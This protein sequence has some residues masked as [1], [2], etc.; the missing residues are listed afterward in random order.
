M[1]TIHEYRRIDEIIEVVC[2][3]GEFSGNIP[4]PRIIFGDK[5][6]LYIKS[7]TLKNFVIERW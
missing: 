1:Y 5:E 6:F 3:W 7:E 2:P 4:P